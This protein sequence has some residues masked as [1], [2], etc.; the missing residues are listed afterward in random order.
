MTQKEKQSSKISDSIKMKFEKIMQ[1]SEMIGQMK[2]SPF[3]VVTMER[4]RMIY[5][6]NEQLFKEICDEL[7]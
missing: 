4:I 2:Q 1:N 5:K 7:V 3:N 6:E